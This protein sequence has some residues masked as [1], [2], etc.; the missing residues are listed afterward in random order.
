MLPL[1]SNWSPLLD[2]ADMI[3]CKPLGDFRECFSMV[4]EEASW[5]SES[6]YIILLN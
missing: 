2:M 3:V 4:E 6:G 1:E 5:K